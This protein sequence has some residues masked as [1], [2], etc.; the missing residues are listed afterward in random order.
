MKITQIIDLIG[1]REY[2]SATSQNGLDLLSAGGRTP[3]LSREGISSLRKITDAPVVSVVYTTHT[4][5]LLTC[6]PE[7]ELNLVQVLDTYSPLF[8]PIIFIK[9]LHRVSNAHTWQ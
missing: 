1:N 7:R 8:T 4:L 2:L 9:T 5:V 6:S 3:W